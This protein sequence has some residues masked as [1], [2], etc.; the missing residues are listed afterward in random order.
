MLTAHELLLLISKQWATVGDIM[1]IGCVGK[2]RAQEIKR[3]IVQ[4]TGK[5]FPYGLVDMK[6]V[7]QYFDIDI[8]YL[9]RVEKKD[10]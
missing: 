8:G 3:E 10:S 6:L 5:I 2:N 9:K 4:S 1:K 7:V